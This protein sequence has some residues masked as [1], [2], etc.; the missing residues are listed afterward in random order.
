MSMRWE[1]WCG[2]IWRGGEGRNSETEVDGRH[3]YGLEGDVL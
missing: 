1:Q 3:K 2:G